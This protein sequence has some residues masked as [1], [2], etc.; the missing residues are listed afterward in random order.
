MSNRPTI[1]HHLTPAETSYLMDLLH[2]DWANRVAR[3]AVASTV[4]GG[5]PNAHVWAY[6]KARASRL[7]NKLDN[8]AY[9]QGFW[10]DGKGL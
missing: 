5:E 8:N 6:L 1:E 4:S 9:D 7:L 2:A 3:G 10:E